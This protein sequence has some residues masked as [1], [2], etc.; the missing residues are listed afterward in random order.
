VLESVFRYLF[1]YERLVFHQGQ[2]VLGA[3][4]SMWLVA[5]IAAAAALYV[6]WTY[7]QLAALKPRDRAVL[8]ASRI[9]LLAVA[10]FA[11]LQPML[12]LKV[13]VP[14]QNYVGV[15]LDDSR[16]MQIADEQ[17]QPRSAFVEQQLGRPESPL[18]KAIGQRFV[19]RVFRVSSSA[20]RLRSSSDL[21]FQG[22]STRLADALDR[23]ADELSGLPVAG[24]VVVSDGADTADVPLDQTIASLKTQAMPVFSIG[25]GQDRLRRDVQVTRAETPRRVLKG[26]SL[27]VDVVVTQTGY[28][29]LKVP[30][31]V[32]VDGRLVGSQTVTLPADGES[33]TVKVRFKAADAGP[34]LFRFRVPVQAREEVAQNNQRD[35]LIDVYNRREKILYIEGEPRPEPKFIRMA[36][37]EDPSLQVVLLQRT[38]EATVSAP[39]KFW[40]AGVDG[41]EELQNGFPQTREELFAYRAIILGSIEAAAFTPAQQRMLEDFVDVRGGGLLALGGDR[42]FAEGGWGGT[43]LADALPIALERSARQAL[44][45]P[46]ELVVKPTREGLSHPATQITDREEDA[47]AKWRDLPPLSAVNTVP[48]SSLKPGATPLLT[49]VDTR[50]REQ[51]V[52]AFQRYGRGKTLVLPVQDTW[53]WRMHAKMAVEDKTHHTF[54]Q[55]LVRWLVDGVPDRVMITGTPDRVQ[56]GE[57]VTLTALVR[58]AEYAGVNEARVSALVT[59]PSGKVQEVPLQWTL[60]GDGEYQARFTPDEDG[61]YKIAAGGTTRVGLDVGRG[62]MALRVAPSDAEYF[63]PAMRQPLLQRL[64]QD[65]GGRFFRA[66]DTSGLLDAIA[67]SGRGVTVVEER[68]LW[69]MPIVLLLLL[70]LMGGEWLFRRSRGLA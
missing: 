51:V 52:L 11:T 27:V 58:D 18:L 62:S 13:A 15:L 3:T 37:E 14:Q 4:R 50:G 17:G 38:A 43:P 35:A 6:L 39:E 10:L 9:A 2:F 8:V 12:L 66:S 33:E 36:T 47:Q 61:L 70:G 44:D 69:D 31:V 34:Q 40:R 63:D 28:A 30:L 67:Y 55:R 22:T 56:R 29:G 53:L 46:L 32:E 26:A 49:G 60:D 19:P 65:T 5:A 1:K 16:S 42:A 48:M 64:A 23:A 24:L 45:P 57:P 68:E 7:W 59:S 41:P 21:T 20:E 54:W 25:V